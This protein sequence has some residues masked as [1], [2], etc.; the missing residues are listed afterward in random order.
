MKIFDLE[1]QIQ[2]CW[3]VVD[4]IKMINALY[5]EEDNS[6]ALNSLS[7]LYELKFQRMWDTFN[8]VCDEYHTMHQAGESEEGLV[9]RG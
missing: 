2:E 6:E 3:N 9:S 7:I 4:D 8:K 1:Q 5:K